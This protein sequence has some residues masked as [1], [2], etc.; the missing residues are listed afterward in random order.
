MD[1]KLAFFVASVGFVLLAQGMSSASASPAEKEE[2]IE[3]APR[4]TDLGWH[5][6]RA[7]DNIVRWTEPL[8]DMDPVKAV[9]EGTG[10]HPWF[11][12]THNVGRAI[13]GLLKGESATGN[14]PPEKVLQQLRSLLFATLDDEVGFPAAFDQDSQKRLLMS[15]D[16]REAV[17][18]LLELGARR[19]DQEALDR[20]GKLMET[21]L[22]I[23]NGEGAYRPDMVNTIPLLRAE[24]PLGTLSAFTDEGDLVYDPPNA[25][26]YHPQATTVDRGRLIMALTQVYQRTGDARARASALTPFPTTV[27]SCRT[28]AT[29][30]TP[31]PV[32]SMDWSTTGGW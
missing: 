3:M 2:G 7:M 9:R 1:W 16:L 26:F 12:L 28:P 31:S 5:V 10:S 29:T 20:L 4:P 30:P 22:R 25:G 24:K 23:T 6:K 8:M 18:A 11:D 27:S 15:H 13:D 32:P 21:L 14:R 19:Q 17:Q